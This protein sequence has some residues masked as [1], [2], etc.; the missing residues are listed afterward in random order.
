MAQRWG[1]WHG[2]RP[3][4]SVEAGAAIQ[5]GVAQVQSGETHLPDAVMGQLVWALFGYRDEQ[6]VS[7]RLWD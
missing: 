7:H 4:T 2:L 5:E 3:A 1:L 6:V